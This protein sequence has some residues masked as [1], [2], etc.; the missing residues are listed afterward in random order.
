MYQARFYS[1]RKVRDEVY[2]DSREEAAR[3]LFLRNAKCET[4]SLCN[5]YIDSY[6]G[7]LRGNGSDCR[8]LHRRD[9]CDEQAPHIMNEAIRHH[10][11]G[12]SWEASLALANID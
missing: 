1:G 11:A 4:A 2:A 6:T 10:E 7:Q 9:V 12:N 8:W 5:A 3:Q